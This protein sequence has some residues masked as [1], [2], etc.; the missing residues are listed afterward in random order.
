MLTL[1]NPQQAAPANHP[2][3]FRLGN[4]SLVSGPASKQ[5]KAGPKSS[6]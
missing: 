1:V 3:W 6:V 2:I 5:A 4:L